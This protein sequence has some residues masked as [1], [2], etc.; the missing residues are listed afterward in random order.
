MNGKPVRNIVSKRQIIAFIKENKR[1]I[2]QLNSIY[3]IIYT[4]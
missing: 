3:N 4:N 2:K 1:I